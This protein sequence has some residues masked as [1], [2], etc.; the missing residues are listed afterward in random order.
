MTRSGV[1]G[2]TRVLA[3]TVAAALCL[4]SC[5]GWG[6]VSRREVILAT[7]TSTQDSGLLD[8]LKPVFEKNTGY[9]LKVIAVGSG[10]ALA[11][12]ERGEADVLLVHS[13]EAELKLV[14]S[15]VVVNRRLVMHNDFV[16]VGPAADPAELKGCHSAREAFRK[17]VQRGALFVSRA[18]DS[19]THRKEMEIWRNCGVVPKGSWYVQAGAGMAQTLRIASEKGGYALSDRGTFLAQKRFLSLEILVEGDP[20]LFNVYHVM[21]VNPDKFTKVNA[22]GA[23]AFAE[24]ILSGEAQKLIGEFGRK[25]YGAPLFI[26][27]AGKK[28][29]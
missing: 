9:L 23:R 8:V 5:L 12:A 29:F 24:F 20:I 4:T 16:I 17:I 14:E 15:G 3:V 10:Q 21:E 22:A 26:P 18:D 13:P 6:G 1:M 19:G 11:M 25:E 7:T 27:D 28:E 2:I